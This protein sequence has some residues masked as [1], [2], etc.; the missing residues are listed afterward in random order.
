MAKLISNIQNQV[1]ENQRKALIVSPV[2]L[3]ASIIL[4]GRATGGV[5]FGRIIITRIHTLGLFL[6]MRLLLGKMKDM[7]EWLRTE[8][9]LRGYRIDWQG[10]YLMHLDY[11]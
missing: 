2:S 6:N 10:K 8:V 11:G 4:Y 7:A 1:Q 9:L 5:S 3:I